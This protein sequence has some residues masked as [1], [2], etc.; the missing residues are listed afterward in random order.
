[1]VNAALQGALDDG[2]AALFGKRPG[3]IAATRLAECHAAQT[4]AGHPKICIS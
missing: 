2:T 4:K 3:V 1:K